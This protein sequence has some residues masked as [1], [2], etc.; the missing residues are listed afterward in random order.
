MYPRVFWV[1][2]VLADGPLPL[3]LLEDNVKAAVA[4]RLQSKLSNM[5]LPVSE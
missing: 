5:A 3:Q 4:R 2:Q 1:A